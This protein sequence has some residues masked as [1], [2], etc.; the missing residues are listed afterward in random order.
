[1]EIFIW[2][3]GKYFILC[4]NL[5]L[6]LARYYFEKDTDNS[7]EVKDIVKNT[8]PMFTSPLDRAFSAVSTA[9]VE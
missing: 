3:S 2:V 6:E 1:M 7:Q 5:T 9:T 4:V 8:N